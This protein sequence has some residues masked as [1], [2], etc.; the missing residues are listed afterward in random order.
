MKNKY[1][2]LV[3]S[4]LLMLCGCDEGTIYPDETIDSGRTASVTV[5]FKGIDAWPKENY[6]SRA[7]FGTDM[8]IPL[9]TKRISKPTID[10]R[11]RTVKL[12]NLSP[13]TKSI[14]IAIISNGKKVIYSYCNQ[15]VENN[16]FLRRH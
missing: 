10:G 8:Q 12:N 11:E 1:T 3:C 6:L 16:G 15:P 7:A 4:F 13:D 9:L 14:N 5:T 2:G